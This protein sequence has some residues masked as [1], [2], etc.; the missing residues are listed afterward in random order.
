MQNLIPQISNFINFLL[1]IFVDFLQIRAYLLFNFKYLLGK[2]II[3]TLILF[4][5]LFVLIFVHLFYSSYFFNFF[6][7]LS[8][9]LCIFILLYLN[10]LCFFLY[11]LSFMHFWAVFTLAFHNIACQG[12]INGWMIQIL[13]PI[14]AHFFAILVSK[15]YW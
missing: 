6:N 5:Y 9:I 11:F 7:A 1:L 2:Y 3:R 8:W 15:V 12:L 14:I 10:N 4:C 13:Y